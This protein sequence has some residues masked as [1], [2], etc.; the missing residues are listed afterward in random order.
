MKNNE[1][2]KNRKKMYTDVVI[3]GGGL[4]GTI[5]REEIGLLQAVTA[6]R[7]WYD[8]VSGSSFCDI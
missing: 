7:A 6:I 1:D 4:T 5:E 2:M 3:V 8:E